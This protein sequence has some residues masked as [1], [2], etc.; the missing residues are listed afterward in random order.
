[1]AHE[2]ARLK[3]IAGI[4]FLLGE[5]DIRTVLDRFFASSLKSPTTPP[6]SGIA[7]DKF[8]AVKL[9][10]MPSTRVGVSKAR[11]DQNSTP[12]SITRGAS[13]LRKA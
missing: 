3:K 7:F 6:K 1:L 5:N 2:K 8:H 13:P 4:C 10:N 12:G 9:A 11:V